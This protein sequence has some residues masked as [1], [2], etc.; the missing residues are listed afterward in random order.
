M[1]VDPVID[2][3]RFRPNRA[4]HNLTS[5]C[6]WCRHSL[7][8]DQVARSRLALVHHVVGRR[9]PARLRVGAL[10]RP[11]C[12][13]G[14]RLREVRPFS[15]KRRLYF[16]PSHGTEVLIQHKNK[17]IAFSISSFIDLLFPIQFDQQRFARSAT[18]NWDL[19]LVH[20]LGPDVR[21]S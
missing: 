11:K 4:D 20:Q 13:P 14:R 5:R 21:F 18:E 16:L 8:P 17:F 3:V 9:S 7:R 19:V 10:R 6:W 2:R 12:R 15:G 1:Y